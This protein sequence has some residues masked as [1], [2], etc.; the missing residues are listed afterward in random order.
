MSR[1]PRHL[2]NVVYSHQLHMKVYH[3][4]QTVLID[5]DFDDSE[6]SYERHA[7]AYFANWHNREDKLLD[8]VNSNACSSDY[9]PSTFV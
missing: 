3:F 5:N 8:S 1:L 2:I 4:V 7:N 6:D 9:C